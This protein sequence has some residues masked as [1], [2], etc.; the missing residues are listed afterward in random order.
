MGDE[1]WSRA[2][3]EGPRERSINS[4]PGTDE[5]GTGQDVRFKLRGGNGA[6]GQT[7][8]GREGD[9]GDETEPSSR[10]KGEETRQIGCVFFESPGTRSSG[11]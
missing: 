2:A 7:P 5:R 11:G 10:K 6:D 4:V 9:V 1:A 3:T 8:A